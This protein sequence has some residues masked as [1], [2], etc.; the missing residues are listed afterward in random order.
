M[1]FL[2][3]MGV[4]F[5]H[6][7][8]IWVWYRYTKNPSVVDVG[9]ASG[10]TIISLLYLYST[11]LSS[12][13]V[14]L[15]L[16]LLIWGFRL[17]GYLWFTRIRQH[18]LDKRYTKLSDNWKIAKPLG[19]LINFQFQGA[20]ILI[21]SLPWYF[22]AQIPSGETSDMIDYFIVLMALLS[23]VAESLADYQLQSFKALHPGQVCDRG[24]WFYSRHP[25]YFFE[26]L[27]WCAFACFAF[28]ASF[29]FLAWISPLMLFGIMTR[30]TAPLTEKGSIESRGE[31]YLSYQKVTPMF[32]PNVFKQHIKKVK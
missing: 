26:W 6:M 13:K 23:I 14:L 29:G 11:P 30:I 17:G 7:C 15:S 5:F 22:I 12:R 31:L 20:L 24:L 10:L 4:I 21:V 8:L 9:W 1:I 25:N 19:F 3:A 28:P 32:F 18:V 27:T 2:M 16:I